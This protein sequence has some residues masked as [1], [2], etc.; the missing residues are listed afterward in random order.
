MRP[1]LDDMQANGQCGAAV[2]LGL[3]EDAHLL[4]TTAPVASGS[5]VAEFCGELLGGV[6]HV[7]TD[8]AKY[9]ERSLAIPDACRR[10]LPLTLPLPSP[11]PM[12]AAAACL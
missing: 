12:L 3:G 7:L 10:R 4:V 5:V 6:D 9:A 11:S 1:A 2:P 8:L